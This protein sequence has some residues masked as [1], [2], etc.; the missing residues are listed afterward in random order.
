[1]ADS[2]SQKRTERN[3]DFVQLEADGLEAG[4]L[5]A[6]EATQLCESAIKLLGWQMV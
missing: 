5:G 6:S 3:D 2:T 1:M 4:I